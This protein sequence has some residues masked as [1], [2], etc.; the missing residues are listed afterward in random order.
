MRQLRH[1]AP[2]GWLLSLLFPLLVAAG[3]AALPPA[4]SSS[5][6]TAA[7]PATRPI[8]RES[9][10][11]SA[12]ERSHAP[13]TLA[14]ALLSAL[15]GPAAAGGHLAVAP[16]TGFAP[17]LPP[18]GSHARSSG[19]ALLAPPASGTGPAR[20]PPFSTGV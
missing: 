2:F 4:P 1:G 7:A 19:E 9:R 13:G 3:P 18:A 11:T 10:D 20:A 6:G 17:L 14:S 5:V 8:S 12:G 15:S 16:R